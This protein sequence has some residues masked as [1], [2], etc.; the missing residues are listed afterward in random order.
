MAEK[1]AFI[2]FSRNRR[3]VDAHERMVFALTA[4]MNFAG[5]QFLASSRL[6]GYE[7]GGVGGGYQF[8]LFNQIGDGRTLPDNFTKVL[9]FQDFFF[10]EGIF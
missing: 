2:E 7:G 6:A 10:E 3:T 5:D 4:A 9:C 1:F 8:D